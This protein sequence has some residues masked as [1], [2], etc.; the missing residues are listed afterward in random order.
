M[1]DISVFRGTSIAPITLVL[2]LLF[3]D[4][5]SSGLLLSTQALF[6]LGMSLRAFAC[7]QKS[8]AS[9]PRSTPQTSSRA[10]P[11]LAS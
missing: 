6:D 7:M 3:T 10:T 11:T 4:I 5:I 2:I 8:S 1:C 9:F